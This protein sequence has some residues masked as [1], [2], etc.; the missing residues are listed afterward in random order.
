MLSQKT[1]GAFWTIL[2]LAAFASSQSASQDPRSRLHPRASGSCPALLAW[3]SQHRVVSPVRRASQHLSCFK[4]GKQRQSPSR[5]ARSL[6]RLCRSQLG[7]PRRVKSRGRH[8]SNRGGISAEGRAERENTRRPVFGTSS[9]F[10]LLP[11]LPPPS[12]SLT[13]PGKTDDCQWRRSGHMTTC[14]RQTNANS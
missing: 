10:L 13:V 5:T 14:P 1:T 2:R 11:L 4:R 3:T 7:V 9:A 8:G 12:S 6:A